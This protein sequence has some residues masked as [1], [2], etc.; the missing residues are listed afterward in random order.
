MKKEGINAI[1]SDY[2]TPELNLSKGNY[3]RYKPNSLDKINIKN[4]IKVISKSN[5]YTHSQ[6]AVSR[7]KKVIAIEGKGGN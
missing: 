4:A 1:K 7:N 3:S 2:F 5:D 6:A